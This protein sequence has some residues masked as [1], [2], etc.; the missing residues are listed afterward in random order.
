MSLLLELGKAF[1][2]TVD[3]DPLLLSI[4]RHLLGAAQAERASIWL[5]DDERAH[6]I[7]TQA[8]GLGTEG[9]LGRSIPATDLQAAGIWT[10]AR[11]IKIDHV[12]RHAEA[13]RFLDQTQSEARN[14]IFAVLVAH[15]ER[16]GA[17]VVANRVGSGFFAD[18]DRAL[19]AALAGHAALAIRNARLHEERDRSH[20]RQRVSERI[21]RHLQQTLDAEVLIP[22]ILQEVNGAIEAE[23]QSLWLVDRETG[24]LACR[25]ATGPRAERIKKVTVP[26]GVGIVGSSVARQVAILVPDAQ[27]EDLVFREA[28]RATGFVTRSLVCVPLLR[29]GAAIGAIEAVNK[30]DGRRFTKEDLD[31]LETIAASA[32]L[33]IENARLYADLSVSYESTLEALMGALDSRDR[34]TEGHSR[35][36][37]EYTA[38]L[39][40][41][42]GLSSAEIAT[43]RRGALIH[44]IGKISIP[45][46]ILNKAGPLDDEERRIMRMHPLTGYEMLF[47]I[48]SLR[49]ELSIVLAHHERWDGTGYPFG[50]AGEAIPLSARLFALSDTF[51]AV[52]SDRPYRRGRTCRE[53]IEVIAGETGRQFDPAAVSAFL[54]VRIEEWEA[55]RGGVLAQVEQR[56]ASKVDEVRESQARFQTSAGRSGNRSA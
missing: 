4:L 33:S 25:Y 19:V 20:E 46:A 21:S 2:S 10:E 14:L 35:R 45:D 3:L 49:D 34:E 50:L 7:C 53:A 18:S 54:A 42:L 24:L 47:G 23:A 56:R 39:A 43:I 27:E 37:R 15:G 8:V 55:I 31:L 11:A 30:R 28:D 41:Q 36:V 17:I 26:I 9:H 44:D 52:T 32:A 48:P 16:L 29:Q 22:L 12:A 5:L 13:R 1:G 40:L 6:L 51:D 38:R